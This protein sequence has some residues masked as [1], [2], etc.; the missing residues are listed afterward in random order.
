MLAK[1]DDRR[2]KR[3][4]EGE[5]DW[6]F[7]LW[8]AETY[9]TLPVLRHH[10]D[11][12]GLEQSLPD[13][14]RDYIENWSALSEARSIEQYRELGRL[15]G[16]LE[17]M[18]AE[19]Y[20]MKG[21][22]I[23]GLV[24][25]DP[26]IRP[27]Q[28]VDIMIKPHH[29][30]RVQKAM[31]GV[32]YKHGVFDPKDGRFHHMFRRITRNTLRHKPALHSFTKVARIPA[33]ISGSTTPRE[34]R[35]RQIKCA[36]NA[37]GSMSMPVFVDFHISLS[38]GMDSEDVWRGA[39]ARSLLGREVNVQSITSMLWFSAARLYQEAF[40]HHTLKLQMLGDIDRLVAVFEDEIDW[41]EFLYLAEKYSLRAPLYYVLEQTCRL[42]GTPIPQE[43]I[44]L[45]GPDQKSRPDDK[46]WGDI[47]PQLLSRTIANRFKLA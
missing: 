17:E 22:A 39:I 18:G 4:L 29:A 7:I 47:L 8:R 6:P 15:L 14:V 35:M 37:D 13:Y 20:L 3:L 30:R 36:F 11:R 25:P 40:E 19:Y 45:L 32:G 43:V 24:Y 5:L 42:N 16:L 10:I 23:A 21:A 41:A 33:P 44:A 1:S 46:D 2:M 26:L 12:L 9:Q 34:W 27:M 28:D 38:A 31:Y